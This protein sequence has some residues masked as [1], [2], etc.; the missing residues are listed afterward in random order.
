M[1]KEY[2]FMEEWVVPLFSVC[3][4][5]CF[6]DRR[7]GACRLKKQELIEHVERLLKPLAEQRQYEIVDVEYEKEGPN[8]YLKVFA[9][10]EG[11]FSINDCVDL[12]HALEAELEKEDPIVNPYIL[13][14][15]SPGLDRPLKKDKDYARSIGKLVEVKLYKAM[16]EPAAVKEFVAKLNAYDPDTAVME[17]EWEDGRVFSLKKKDVAAIRLAVIF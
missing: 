16:E 5:R 15:S 13:E 17:L 4:R 11:G 8:W 7:K 12:S 10:K 9:D 2:D 3:Y 6:A 1:I 14:I